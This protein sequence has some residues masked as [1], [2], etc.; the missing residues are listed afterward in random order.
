MPMKHKRSLAQQEVYQRN[1]L[2]IPRAL[3]ARGAWM[4]EL[5]RR[6]AKAEAEA[7][8]ETEAEAEFEEEGL[9]AREAEAKADPEAEVFDYEE[10]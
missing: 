9:W 2:P 5:E 4:L 3:E 7:E 1:A 10:V 8:A 6:A